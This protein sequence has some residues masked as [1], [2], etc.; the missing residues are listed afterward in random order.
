MRVGLFPGQGIAA[1]DVLAALPEDDPLVASASEI[2]GYDLRRKVRQAC[3]STTPVLPTDL[4]QPA[5]FVAGQVALRDTEESF[6]AFFGH[7]LGEY[8]ALAASGS[9]S[10]KDGV[11]LVHARGVAMQRAAKM[12]PGGMV[13]L[14]SLDGDQVVAI[15]DRSG[16]SVA[17]FNTP[18]Q[19]VLSGSREALAGASRLA[20]EAGGRAVLLP[21]NGPFHSA[22][23]IP[24][25]DRLAEAL[26]QAT[27]RSPKVPVVSGVTA[28]PYRSPGE[29]RRLLLQQ[30]TGPIV[31]AQG[32]SWLIARGADD[33]RDLGP[34]RVVGDLAERNRRSALRL[35]ATVGT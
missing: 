1:S 17:N 3:R 5:I 16:C 34:G 19:H 12:S 35:E 8:S 32:V 2:L 14:L 11:R 23:M 30:L 25:A 18:S 22:A 4:A 33:F 24:A 27:V 13:A 21:V 28:R 15:C 31:F 7:S 10:F 29:I 26:V 6:D 9:F 20:R